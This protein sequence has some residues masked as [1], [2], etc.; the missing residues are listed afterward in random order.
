MAITITF[1]L[2]NGIKGESQIKANEIDVL[3][4]N[5]GMT[6]SASA[7]VSQGASVGSADVRDL[8]ITKY[9]DKTSP[10]LYKS[11]FQGTDI[12]PAVLTVWKSGGGSTLIP[13]I[14]VT[15]D[16]TVFISSINTGDTMDER[17]IETVTFNFATVQFDY[18]G[19]KKDQSAEATV[20]GGL[21]EIAKK[22]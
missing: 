18:T 15:M 6:Q 2:G 21:L 10:V 17:Y 22:A 19:Q 16:G 9:V 12:R 5:W 11:C 3:S 13:M 4:W 14:K 7:H 8:T 1:S 20:Q